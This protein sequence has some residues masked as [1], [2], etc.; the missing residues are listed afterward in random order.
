MTLGAEVS[1]RYITVMPVITRISQAQW[2]APLRT[3]YTNLLNPENN[4]R[5]RNV[6]LPNEED[7]HGLT[8]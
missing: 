3:T 5:I 7:S 8:D 4:R 1:H 2:P 6:P